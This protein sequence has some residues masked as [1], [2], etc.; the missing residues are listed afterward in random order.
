MPGMGFES[1]IPVFERPKTVRASDRRLG[2]VGNKCTTYLHTTAY[3]ACL[4]AERQE[5]CNATCHH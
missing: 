2:T 3:T 5:G 1:T 4:I